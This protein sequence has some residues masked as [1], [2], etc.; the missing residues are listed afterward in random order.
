MMAEV[1]PPKR[2]LLQFATFSSMIDPSF[3]H[4]LSKLKLNQIGLDESPIDVSVTF[5]SGECS[6]FHLL[7]NSVFN[8]F[9]D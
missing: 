3:W 5:H 8:F 6:H 1:T 2:I 4:S 9:F 7:C